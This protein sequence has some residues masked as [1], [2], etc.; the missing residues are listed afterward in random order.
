MILKLVS[1]SLSCMCALSAP[2]RVERGERDGRRKCTLF[3][4]LIVSVKTEKELAIFV[5]SSFAHSHSKFRFVAFNDSMIPPHESNL[6]ALSP[7]ALKCLRLGPSHKFSQV[8]V[9][10]VRAN[11]G[12]EGRSRN[13]S[14]VLI[15]LYRRR[16]LRY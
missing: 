6:S 9:R 16:I 7:L 8:F 4:S 11:E 15:I 5:E 14:D 2:G 3:F 1:L 13:Q 10:G 12:F